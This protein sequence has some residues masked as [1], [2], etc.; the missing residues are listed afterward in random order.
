[1]C[2]NYINLQTRE[3][4]DLEKVFTLKEEQSNDKLKKQLAKENGVEHYISIDARIS[5]LEWIKNSVMGSELTEL[6]DLSCVDWN[7]VHENSLK[8][9]VKETCDLWNN[10]IHSTTKIMNIL[11]IARVTVIDYLKKGKDSGICDYDVEVGIKNS[12]LI[13]KREVV[14][15]SADGLLMNTFDSL[16][17]AGKTIKRSHGKISQCCKGKQKTSGGYKWMY[18]EDYDKYIEEQNSKLA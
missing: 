13:P 7:G 9:L 18:K 10:G 5:E 16:T 6:F 8:S 14:Q 12:S 15:L 2:N 4:L 17:N 11:K 3:V 1:M